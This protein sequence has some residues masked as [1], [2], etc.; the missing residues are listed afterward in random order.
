M[1]E[2]PMKRVMVLCTGNRCRSQM[3]EGWIRHFAGHRINVTSAG[4]TPGQL[5]PLAVKV[6]TQAGVD[7]SQHRSDHVDRYRNDRFDMVITVCDRAAQSCPS[8]ANAGQ[9]IHQPLE[10]PDSPTTDQV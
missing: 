3:A 9:V 4:T 8:F 6:M 2:T 1:T 10:D 7:I 5:H